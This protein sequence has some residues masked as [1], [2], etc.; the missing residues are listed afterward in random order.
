MDAEYNLA[1]KLSVLRLLGPNLYGNMPAVLSEL[2]A[3]AWDADATR[4]DINIDRGKRE[5]EIEDNGLG[6]SPFDINERY[7]SVGYEK[8]K[9]EESRVTPSGR[10]VMGRKGIGKLAIFSFASRLSESGRGRRLV[11]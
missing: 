11:N 5:I 3:N 7:L 2:V 10:H 9:T 4:V 6:I 1:V 8:R